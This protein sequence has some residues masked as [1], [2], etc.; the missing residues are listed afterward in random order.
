MITEKDVFEIRNIVLKAGE[1]IM[2]IYN[3]ADFAI[4]EKSDS[5]PVTKA[6][7]Q[8]DKIL[9][10]GLC[11]L[12]PSQKIVTEERQESHNIQSESFFLIDPL[13]GTKEFINRRGQFTV[14]IAWIEKGV[15]KFG[16][17][18]APALSR[19]F[20][21][22]GNQ[23]Y[24]EFAPFTNDKFGKRTPIHTANSDNNAL[25]IVASKSHR[26][27]ETDD[28][29]EKYPNASIQS[30]G[31]SLKFCLIAT[32]E[33]DLYPRIGPTMEWDTA[34]ADAIVRAAGGA[35]LDFTTH[36][37]LRYGKPEYRNGYFL[38]ASK[39]VQLK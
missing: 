38:A 34:A 8:A 1:A 14:N 4:E 30:A 28:Y 7:L 3:S 33:A 21:T 10:E 32:G 17:V 2:Q 36:E 9:Y 37:P 6:D 39:S 20:Y 27:Q 22:I 29:I 35:V 12:F 5:S 31:S 19:L 26:G 16:I 11:R 25:R 13:D 15:P 18:F 23:S 24:E